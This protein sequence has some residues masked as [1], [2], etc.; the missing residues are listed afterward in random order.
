MCVCVGV[1]RAEV[2]LF[3][4]S[5]CYVVGH[6]AFP[7]TNANDRFFVRLREECDFHSPVKS[8]SPVSG[9]TGQ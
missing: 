5:H 9:N 6:G 7:V 8:A 3:Q 4:V 1:C 2:V